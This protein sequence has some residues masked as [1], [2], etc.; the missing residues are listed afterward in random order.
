[1][2]IDRL[3]VLRLWQACQI[4]TSRM[5]EMRHLAA[6]ILSFKA[7]FYD[8]VERATGVPWYVIG[9]MDC[10]EESFKH[11]GY[12]GNGDPLWRPTTHVPRGRGP[13]KTWYDGAIDALVMRGFNH[14]PQGGHWDIVTAL[15][16]AE[17]YNGMGYASHGLPSPYVWGGTNI[18]QP[19]KYVADGVWSSTTWD[20]QPGCAAMW[21]ALKTFQLVNLNEA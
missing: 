11:G 19:G 17:A 18:Q 16:K 3:K 12:L 15:I 9:A 8:P 2:I 1:M 14:L 5:D 10:R 6:L 20:S 21:L 13:F 7:E 4:K